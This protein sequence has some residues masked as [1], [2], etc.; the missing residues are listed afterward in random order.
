VHTATIPLASGLTGVSSLKRKA[1]KFDIVYLGERGG[2][3]DFE[4]LILA[5]E[6]LR[7]PVKLLLLGGG[8]IHKGQ[9]KRLDNLRNVHVEA[10]STFRQEDLSELLG[11]CRVYVS[12]SKYE[13]FNIGA[14]HAC[15]LGLEMVLSDISVHQEFHGEHARFA[16]PGDF[17]NLS[18]QIR[19]ALEGSQ[20]YSRQVC[21]TARRTWDNVAAET[22]EFYRKIYAT[23]R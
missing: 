11:D 23:M 16:P 17:Q 21:S 22:A 18:L 8:P 19:E 20:T 4:S 7:F 13:G 14:S 15:T 6:L 5:L 12:T 2:Y 9:A 10:S 3:K 1:P